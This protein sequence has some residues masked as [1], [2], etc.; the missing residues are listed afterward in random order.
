MW[1]GI[2]RLT[3]DYASAVGDS[4]GD[5][6]YNTLII[7]AG[8]AIT[9]SDNYVLLGWI[10][11]IAGNDLAWASYS[12]E[13]VPGAYSVP[14]T[15]DGRILRAAGLDGPY[16]LARIELRFGKDARLADETSDAHITGAYRACR[17]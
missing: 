1:P 3:G 11:D 10:Q 6:L 9:T 16:R 13:W 5:A 4:D 17:F 12:A 14:L 2:G 8:L 15:F 7:T